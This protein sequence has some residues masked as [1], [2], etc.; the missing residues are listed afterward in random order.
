VLWLG[1]L[2]APGQVA[3]D[4]LSEDAQ[5]ALFHDGDISVGGVVLEELYS[6][7]QDDPIGLGWRL[8]S[9][10]ETAAPK[11][12]DWAEMTAEYN[13]QRERLTTVLRGIGIAQDP[14]LYLSL[15]WDY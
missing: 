10:D 9:L 3:D 2:F 8:I 1:I 12:L 4:I 7:T 15:L 14:Q 11:Q 6:F 13:D 5:A